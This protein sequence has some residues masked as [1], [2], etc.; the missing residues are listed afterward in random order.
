MEIYIMNVNIHDYEYQREW[1]VT[2][3]LYSRYE[4]FD[5]YLYIIWIL[6]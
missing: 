4:I 1:K 6:K 2:S 5:F 3:K